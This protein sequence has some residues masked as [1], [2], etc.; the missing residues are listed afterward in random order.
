MTPSPTSSRFLTLHALHP[1]TAANLNR[2][3]SG[4]P[5]SIILGDATRGMVSSAA[6]KRVMRQ[7]ME[8]D[9]GESAARTRMVPLAVAD[10]LREQGWP[11]D[12]AQFTAMQIPLSAKDGGI[13]T[14][15]KEGHRT[16]AMLFLPADA[17]SRLLQICIAHRENL[18]QALAEQQATGEQAPAVLPRAKV[19]AE[20]IRRTA[21]I[22]LFGRML[23]EIPQGQVESAVQMA[24]AFT[25]HKTALQPDFFTAVEDWPR[26]GDP[27]SAH[28]D[29]AF[30]TAGIF[31]RFATVN[32]TTLTA[33][34]DSDNATL[35][36]LIELFVWTFIM[37]MPKGK[38]T[39]SAAHTIPDVVHYAVRDRRP[40]SYG[41]AFEQ[42]VT[43]HG[44]GYTAPARQR[45]AQY[46]ATIDRL[47]GTR[48]RIA[49]GHATAAGEAIDHLGVCHP[50]FADLA[51]AC[52][53]AALAPP[54]D[55]APQTGAAPADGHS[56][57]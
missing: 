51:T 28:L 40:I 45:L 13:K 16:Q 46:A 39:S 21:T 12:L 37:S 35:A 8:A 42:P 31:Y 15:P 49:H 23:A 14:D 25:V 7:D 6:W 19:A 54:T 29:T 20:L 38:Q 55:T 27:G 34:Q 24:P 10:A 9:L 43:A 53:T 33:N 17:A 22:N 26:P 47:V 41:A 52:A 4:Q 44:Q 32:I 36:K 56:A 57:A 3:E 5:K 2:G 11:D 50:S 18:E 30:L 1:I 48:H